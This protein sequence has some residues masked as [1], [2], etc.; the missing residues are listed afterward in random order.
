MHTQITGMN[1]DAMMQQTMTAAAVA[2]AV[3]PASAQAIPPP[4]AASAAPSP[5]KA[6]PEGSTGGQVD[7][8][9]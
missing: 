6:G 9:L 3:H 8:L 7:V 5:S 4:D 1:I 2:A